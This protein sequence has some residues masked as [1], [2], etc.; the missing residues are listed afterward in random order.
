MHQGK[1][2]GH[3][4]IQGIGRVV[5]LEGMFTR[6]EVNVVVKDEGPHID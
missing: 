5:R 4:G 6:K 3:N 1:G 2:L